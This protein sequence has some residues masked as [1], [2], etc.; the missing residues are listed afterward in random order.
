MFQ[1][2][3]RCVIQQNG[4]VLANYLFN[5]TDTYLQTTYSTERIRTCKLLI[6]QNGYVLANYLF[7]RT[8]TYLQT[9]P[10]QFGFK[11]KHGTE[12][13]VFA[14]KELLQFYTK[15]G[16]AGHVAFLDASKAFDRINRH[17]LLTKLAQHDGLEHVSRVLGN[18]QGFVRFSSHGQCNMSHGHG[19]TCFYFY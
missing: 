2:T 6:Q 17:K 9:T 11:P 12:L 3:R 13:C 14:F 1:D 16:S 7:N 18:E 5:R 8:D 19:Q 15:H 10:H 4:Y